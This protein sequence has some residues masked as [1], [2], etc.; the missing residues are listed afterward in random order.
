LESFDDPANP[1]SYKYG[2][3]RRT[4]V[5]WTDTVKV[6]TE[7]G[8]EVRRYRFRKTHHGPIIG[9]SQWQSCRRAHCSIGRRRRTGTAHSLMNR[10]RNLKEFR[11]ALGKLSLTGSNTLYADNQRQYFLCSR[12]LGSAPFDKV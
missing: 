10:A 3:E 12:Q 2:N 5:E 8:I 6:K 11:A 4:A 1:L 7:Q 9:L